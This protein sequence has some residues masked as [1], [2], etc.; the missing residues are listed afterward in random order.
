VRALG[1]GV[2]IMPMVHAGAVRRITSVLAS[3]AVP[4]YLAPLSARVRSRAT[5]E[6][7]EVVQ[8]CGS[9]LAAAA[10]DVPG[11]G[12]LLLPRADPDRGRARAAFLRLER[13]RAASAPTIPTA[14][15]GGDA[16]TTAA[17]TIEPPYAESLPMWWHTFARPASHA[18]EQ[19]ALSVPATIVLCTRDRPDLL[20]RSVASIR[21]ALAA[22]PRSELIVVEQSHIAAAAAIARDIG[23]RA[24]VIS[25]AGS[26]V[27]RARNIGAARAQTD[28]LLFTDDDCEVPHDWIEQHVAALADPDVAAS[29]GP[30]TGLSRDDD[31]Y[32][33]AAL[34]ARHRHG[35]PPWII[36]HSAN[37]AVR[38][39]AFRAVGGFDERIG[40]GI[41]GAT[42][43]E[44]ADLIVR[45]LRL[46]RTVVGGSGRPVR[47]IGWRS[48]EDDA[49][50]LIAYERGAGVWIGKGLRERP[51]SAGRF[52]AARLS[53]LRARAKTQQRNPTAATLARAFAAGL[54]VGIGLGPWRG[55]NT[56]PGPR[57]PEQL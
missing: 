40:P 4:R 29:F 21:D 49:R 37:M 9:R 41:P 56:L 48:E 25:D 20:K 39:E 13:A 57:G 34:P 35:S 12:L 11:A 44:D 30:V 23:V 38:R 43:G 47:H 45:L 17:T 1:A 26:G 31:T 36:G 24:D 46:G 2:E 16:E 50:N 54:G 32:D 28:I 52:A 5:E 53:A 8:I 3:G 55:P 7:F 19:P 22:S 15:L 14:R 6:G 18:V 42:A 33:P 27:S 10:R 51:L